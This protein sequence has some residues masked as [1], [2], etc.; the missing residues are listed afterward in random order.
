MISPGTRK[1]YSGVAVEVVVKVE[2]GEEVGEGVNVSVGVTVKV[3]ETVS[4]GDGSGV[5]VNV[6]SMIGVGVMTSP[7]PP[8]PNVSSIKARSN[9]IGR[10]SNFIFC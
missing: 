1:I 5:V 6:D 10:R 2:V 8:H 7:K 3:G 4:L 9:F